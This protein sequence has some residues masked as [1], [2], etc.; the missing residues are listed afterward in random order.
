MY[1]YQRSFHC[2]VAKWDQFVVDGQTEVAANEWHYVAAVYDGQKMCLYVDGKIDACKDFKG[3][4]GRNDF[5]VLIG[6]NAEQTGRFFG[7]II[8][9]VR[10]YNYAL[11][12]DKIQNLYEGK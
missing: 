6:E 7:G 11:T 10:V 3:G 12:A 2:S 4:I 1:D 8:D 5:E 9:D